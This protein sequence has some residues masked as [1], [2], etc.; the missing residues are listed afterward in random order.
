ML[1][2]I[3]RELVSKRGWATN[4][5]LADYYAIGQCTPGVIAVNTSTFVGT[6]LC[7]TRG[8]IVA[9]LGFVTPS[10][11]VIML[12]AGC[13]SNFSDILWVQKAFMGIRVCVC[14][15]IVKALVSLWKSAIKDKLTFVL[16]LLV[17]VL[18]IWL[19]ISPVYIVLVDLA[20]ALV[21]EWMRS[22]SLLAQKPQPKDRE[23]A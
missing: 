2:V 16:F 5:D 11:F 22:A 6:S 18:S 4:E 19:H 23:D 9:T 8:G 21:L 12:I 20:F 17:V 14:V 1:P 10:F 15:L 7:G 13:I 3:E